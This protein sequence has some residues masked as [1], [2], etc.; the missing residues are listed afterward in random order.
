MGVALGKPQPLLW[1]GRGFGWVKG[2]PTYQ[3]PECLGATV[4]RGM[5]SHTISTGSHLRLR[6]HACRF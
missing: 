3:L 1:G 6:L 2:Q 4:Y 5:G